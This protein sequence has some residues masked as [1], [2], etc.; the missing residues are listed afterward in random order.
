MGCMDGRME[1]EEKEW[2][3]SW[4]NDGMDGWMDGGRRKE[5]DERYHGCRNKWTDRCG[6]EGIEGL[7]E[8]EMDYVEKVDGWMDVE[9]KGWTDGRQKPGRK[10]ANSDKRMDKCWGNKRE[11]RGEQRVGKEGKEKEKTSV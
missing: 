6:K 11:K 2:M 9:K 5:M 4:R 8:G 10:K 3:H 7:K 1:V